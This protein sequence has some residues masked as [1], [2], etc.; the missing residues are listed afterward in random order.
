MC[1]YTAVPEKLKAISHWVAW[2]LDPVKGKVPYDVKTA[3][4]AKTND[5]STWAT[6]KQV[7]DAVDILAGNDY[8]GIGFVL[9]DT[10]LVGSDFDGMLHDGVAEPFALEILKHLGNPYCESSPSGAGLHAFVECA[11]LPPGQRKFSKNHYGMEVYSGSEKGR[12]LTVTGQ[13]FSGNGVPK[14]ADIGLAYLLITQARN[15]KFKDLWMGDTAAYGDRS[16]DDPSSADLA[17]VSILARLLNG[18]RARIEKYFGTSVLGQRD[19]WDTSSR[20]SADDARQST[21]RKVIQ[22]WRCKSHQ[23]D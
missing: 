20:L 15:T 19:K 9:L 1:S 6:F 18:D 22:Q 4:K 7:V 5:P 16:T 11:A 17:L 10:P 14:I 3:R 23:C 2:K 13:Q 21:R 8:D 12:F